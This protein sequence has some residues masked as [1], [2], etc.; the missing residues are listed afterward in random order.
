LYNWGKV[1]VKKLVKA[2]NAGICSDQVWTREVVYARGNSQ[3]EIAMI[4][5]VISSPGDVLHPVEI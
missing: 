4:H 3:E 5:A 2:T 1:K